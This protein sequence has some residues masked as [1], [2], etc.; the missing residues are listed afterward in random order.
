MKQMKRVTIL[1][2]VVMCLLQMSVWGADKGTF[3]TRPK[4]NNG[5]KWR[6]GY[7]EGGPFIDYQMTL[8]A[9][10]NGLVE[11]GWIEPMTIPEQQGIQTKDLW[12]W[13][14]ANSKSAYLEF[15]SDAH[16]SADWN[17]EL[18]QQM[19]ADIITRVNQQQ[20]LDMILATGT[21]AGVD[22]ANDKHHTPTIVLSSSDP[23]SARDCQK[24]GRF[25]L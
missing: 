11:L 9:T 17:K 20:D 21:W 22:L 24:C 12:N 7:Y 2:I 15:V 25:R 5:R 18:R 13:L 14:V 23:V 16:Y 10:V 1:L 8:I 4:T 19:T 6:I 3:Q